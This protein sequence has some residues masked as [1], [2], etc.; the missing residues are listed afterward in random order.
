VDPLPADVND[1]S[2]LNFRSDYASDPN[3]ERDAKS[4]PDL[5]L[6][7][8]QDELEAVRSQL[9]GAQVELRTLRAQFQSSSIVR[10]ALDL[11]KTRAVRAEGALRTERDR[12][13]AALAAV[14]DAQQKAAAALAQLATER[15]DAAALR[16]A[17]NEAASTGVAGMH[18][19]AGPTWDG[20]AQ[21]AVAA[22]IAEVSDWRVALK[23][24][25]RVLGDQGGWDAVVAWCPEERRPT[26]CCMGMWTG[27]D[28][29]LRALETQT[30]QARRQP[31]ASEFG[32]A[33]AR[34]GATCIPSLDGAEDRLLQDAA[35]AGIGSVVYVPIRVENEATGVIELWSRRSA[36]PDAEVVRFLEAIG[37]Q[38]GSHAGLI[39]AAAAPR[40]R[41]GRY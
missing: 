19:T 27:H 30:W 22:A 4:R 24:I 20:T 8:T 16:E 29:S 25:V 31:T 5:K 40:W 35:Q 38:L 33:R 26:F 6:I 10:E 9:E 2:T 12:A 28:P 37:L 36:E 41:V 3:S 1:V 7:A 18:L 21:H 13:E 39:N 14:T 34:P 17:L 23:E 32:A 15:Q 11:E